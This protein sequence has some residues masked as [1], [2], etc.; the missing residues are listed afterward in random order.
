MNESKTILWYDLETFGLNPRVDRI[1]QAA[2]IRTDLSLNAVSEPIL[3]Y[4]KLSD[5][6][7]PNPESCVL[8]GITPDDVE[9]KGIREYD[10][11]KRLNDEFL[12]PGTIGCGYNSMG[13]DD[14]C[15]R[16]T[17]YR[18][19]FDPYE[20][21]NFQ[22][23]SR[24][25]IINL[26]RATRDLRPD[27][28]CFDIRNPETGWTSFRLTDLTEENGINQ[29]GAH[30]ALVDVRA[31]IA[32]ARLIKEKQPRLYAYAFQ[33]RTKNDVWGLLDVERMT[34]M[35]HTHPMYAS[36]RGNTH[37]VVPIWRNRKRSNEIWCYDLTKELPS[38]V[39]TLDIK[40]T[41]LVRIAANKCPF[42]AP[43]GVLDRESE[44]RLGFTR[45]EIEERAREI[46]KHRDVLASASER[47]SSQEFTDEESDP[48]YTIYERFISDA[49]KAALKKISMM[50]PKDK[51]ASGEHN[52]E[53]TKYH[54]L[55][56]RQVARNWP[57]VL[58]ENERRQW[59][60][61]CASRLINPP[62]RSSRTLELF[63]RECQD[64]IDSIET[65]ADR[66]KIY[67]NLKNWALRL[68][69]RIMS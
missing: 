7:L 39:G 52:F 51:L 11:I 38:D 29:E 41:G 60:N 42:I 8:T 23:R 58:N 59:K 57:E 30:D 14:E 26:V 64:G 19:L 54:K 24:W 48:D 25:D 5:D 18:N 15:I 55:L 46:K 33:H 62:S 22:G 68:E 28:I 31:T 34:P 21:E 53:D 50:D 44:K 61:F 49:D 27:G 43:L 69:E 13:F 20:R 2:A 37:P 36:E 45:K 66:K 3:L 17:L 35:L 63:L 9:E 12:V 4:C 56:W 32:I 10:F 16:S 6:Y 65:D 40:D 67:M 1:A 47:F